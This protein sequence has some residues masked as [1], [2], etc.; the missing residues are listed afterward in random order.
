MFDKILLPL[1]GSMLAERSIPHALEFARIFNSRIILCRV[2]EPG[3]HT[4]NVQLS[5]PLHWQLL[6][7]EADLYMQRITDQIRQELDLPPAQPDTVQ[8]ERVS[9]VILE[10]KIAESIVDF[11]HKESTDLLIIGTHGSGGLSPWHFNSV[12]AKVISLIYTPVLIIRA[13]LSEPPEVTRP[14]YSRILLPID[15]SR[16]AEYAFTA[17]IALAINK[18][19]KLILVSVIK[20]PDVPIIEPYHTQIQQL[21]E[22][23]IAYSHKAI[24]LYLEE[25]SQRLP[26]ETENHIIENT[27]VTDAILKLSRE[28]EADLLVL[29]AH[30]HTGGLAWP[31]GTVARNIMEYSQL[32]VLVIQDLSR[33]EVKPSELEELVKETRSRE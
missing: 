26:V 8:T 29:C 4:D 31:F 19:S 15:C 2:I 25:I 9:Y 5:D 7:T 20:P 12:V 16:R 11:A 33:S 14:N 24:N 3:A 32:P 23:L 17:G 22:E 21:R 13:Y 30:G 28:E 27:S 6:K 1:D 18:G 10:G